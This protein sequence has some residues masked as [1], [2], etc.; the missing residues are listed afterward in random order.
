MAIGQTPR[1]GTDAVP[2]NREVQEARGGWFRDPVL[3]GL[4]L[5]GAFVAALGFPP[6]PVWPLALVAPAP[7]WA[8]SVGGSPGRAFSR[9]W[10]YGAGFFGCLLWWIVPTVVRYGGLPWAAGGACLVL[11]AGYLAL[12][13]AAGAAAVAAASRR[14]PA[15]ALVLAPFLW[16]GLEGL[17]GSLLTGFPWGDL[18]Q[19]LWQQPWALALAPWVGIEG[20]RLWTATLASASAWGLLRWGNRV[21]AGAAPL[22]L[23]VG[24]CAVLL[25]LWLLP[26]PLPPEQGRLRAAVIQG[27]IEQAQ[28]WDPA[29]RQATL[30]TYAELSRLAARSEPDLYVWPETAVPLYA[31]DPSPERSGLEALARELGAPLIFGAPAYERGEDRVEYRNAVF[32]MAPSGRL[33]GRYDKVHLVPFGEYVPF[34]RYLPFLDKLVAGAGDFT[35]GRAVEPLP[36]TE[37][38]PTLG[39]LVCFEVIFPSLAGELARR[40]AQVLVV[41]TNDGW[42]G[43]TPGPYQH[44]AF[45]AWRAAEAGVPLLRAANTGVSAVF[46]ARGRLLQASALQVADVLAAEVSYGAPHR[47]PQHRIRPLVWPGCL[48]LAL[49]ALFA[50]VR[51]LRAPGGPD[52]HR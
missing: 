24:T 9:G 37:G 45:G 41:V 42:F 13:P 35:S 40:G 11:L 10:A 43:R 34:G 16:V 4:C 1:S 20:V 30:G 50:M 47:T 44:L 31:Q 17:R 46:D 6:G 22:G 28:K 32:V 26:P 36:P 39:A 18:P 29:F 51:S 52:P 3:W 8:S 27:N 19:A 33:L 25:V 21:P 14:S 15:G 48:V 23:A 2:G 5:W 49:L 38:L 7:L 12:Y